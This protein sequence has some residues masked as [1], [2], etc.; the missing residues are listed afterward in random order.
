VRLGT[1]LD[2]GMKMTLN[3]CDFGSLTQFKIQ[4]IEDDV[5]FRFVATK[6]KR[7]RKFVNGNYSAGCCT[8]RLHP[9]AMD[10]GR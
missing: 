6:F 10:Q 4:L 3:G 2:L 8:G 9:R 1:R 5:K 7:F